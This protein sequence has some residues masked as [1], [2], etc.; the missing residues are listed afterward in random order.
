MKDHLDK[1]DLLECLEKFPYAERVR[2]LA[3]D[4]LFAR[5]GDTLTVRELEEVIVHTAG[6]RASERAAQRVLEI[7]VY[8]D[9]LGQVV[10]SK[11]L[12]MSLRV[13]AARRTLGMGPDTVD[14][15]RCLEI[16]KVATTAIFG[17]LKP[18]TPRSTL[19]CII[20]NHPEW[21][22]AVHKYVA[23]NNLRLDLP[24]EARDILG[25]LERESIQAARR[26]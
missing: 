6:M 23:D 15:M 5:Y 8:K 19:R 14:L 16:P 18:G 20:R 2:G 24:D 21:M 25:K 7:A 10:I 4:L 1:E 11:H 17:L 9:D 22:A 26:H 3:S 13:Q 12:P